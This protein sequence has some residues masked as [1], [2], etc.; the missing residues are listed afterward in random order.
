MA[1]IR[2]TKKKKK[3]N[4]LKTSFHLNKSFVRGVPRIVIYFIL[5][6]NQRNSTAL[7]RTSLMNV[8]KEYTF[9]C[10]CSSIHT[11]SHAY[12]LTCLHAHSFVCRYIWI[13]NWIVVCARQ[14][15]IIHHSRSMM[16][17]LA[18]GV[19]PMWRD[20]IFLAKMSHM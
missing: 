3:K 11:F 20:R 4:T 7:N 15:I 9:T 19:P 2:I 1:Q 13:E 8:V 18:N 14:P 6:I 17:L 16:S 5:S 10:T 12:M